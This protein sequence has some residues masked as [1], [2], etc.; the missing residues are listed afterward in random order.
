MGNLAEG[1]VD[2]EEG[3]QS[4]EKEERPLGRRTTVGDRQHRSGEIDKH[5][6]QGKIVIRRADQADGGVGKAPAESHET[7][8]EGGA[9]DDLEKQNDRFYPEDLRP[10]GDDEA[11]RNGGGHTDMKDDE[12][13][14]KTRLLA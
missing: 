10:V 7:D 2:K 6:N 12:L 1:H 11:G 5:Q 14:V 4:E 9:H 8:E 3:L 13:D